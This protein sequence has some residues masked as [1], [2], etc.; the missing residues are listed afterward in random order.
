MDWNTLDSIAQVDALI[1]E[2]NDNK[3]VIFKNSTSCGISRMVLKNFQREV[4]S[5]DTDSIK[6]YLL[7]LLSYR[8]VSTY[9][10]EKLD[11]RHESPQMIILQDGK[12]VHHDSHNSI[13][14]SS[15]LKY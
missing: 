7:D 5:M 12:V 2:S 8:S 4:D 10:A 6:F 15:A 13:T 1:N 3:I 11:V 14:A 9:I